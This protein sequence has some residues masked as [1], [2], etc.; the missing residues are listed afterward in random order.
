GVGLYKGPLFFQCKFEDNTFCMWNLAKEL[1][2]APAY[3]IY[4]L[5]KGEDDTKVM[6]EAG[7]DGDV[8]YIRSTINASYKGN[9]DVMNNSFTTKFLSKPIDSF[10]EWKEITMDSVFSDAAVHDGGELLIND[11][12]KKRLEYRTI[13]EIG[14]ETSDTMYYARLARKISSMSSITF[15][16]DR[17]LYLIPLARVGVSIE[18]KPQ[19]L[20]YADLEG[21]Y[22][23]NNTTITLNRQ[24]SDVWVGA[25]KINAFRGNLKKA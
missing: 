14:Y 8:Y 6:R 2:S 9:L 13:G 24:N 21:K 25:V 22:I 17:N 19:A 15:T 1:E 4:H 23:V 10:T 5:A 20:E 7:V 18:L 3:T 12:V 11:T 16:V